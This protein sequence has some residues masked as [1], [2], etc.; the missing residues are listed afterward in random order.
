MA[1]Q[2]AFIRCFI[3]TGLLSVGMHCT[4]QLPDYHVRLFDENYG[5]R[6]DQS[7]VIRDRSGFVWIT[8][9]DRIQRFDGKKVKEFSTNNP[10][11][12]LFCD[13]EN[14]IWIATDTMIYRF[15]NDYRGFSKISVDTGTKQAI[16]YFFT[17]PG[18][19]V[20]V[21][22]TKG[23]YEWD[24]SSGRFKLIYLPEIQ[25]RL[26]LLESFTA[27]YKNTFFFASG[28]SI[29][30]LNIETHHLLSL[31]ANDLEKVFPISGDL[32]LVTTHRAISFW[33]DFSAHAITPVNTGIA[34]GKEG[35]NFLYISAAQQ[36]DTDHF[37]LTSHSGVFEL[38]LPARSFRCLRLY[39]RG[40]PLELTPLYNSISIDNGKTA[41]LTYG[42]GLVSFK[43]GQETIGLIRN[44]ETDPEKA[45]LNNVRNFAKDE[46]GN[47][48]IA[49]S[50]G[51]GYWNL[52]DNSIRMFP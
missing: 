18:K 33:Y 49:T 20:C 26:P 12:S 22:A 48:W 15:T 46:K 16:G 1:H 10:T 28:D 30:A 21:S 14:K 52:H 8:Y 7:K 29:F 37:L 41:W 45:W 3:A 42:G 43:A 4:G 11:H 50:Q 17:F 38:S 35:T 13:A 44:Q 34:H 5:L 19:N 36:L 31:P 2:A 32:H 23:F 27:V 25:K 51:F 24:R 9:S 39:Y 47:L 6:D 40:K